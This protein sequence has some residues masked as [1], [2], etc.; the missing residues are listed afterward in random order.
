MAHSLEQSHSP[1]VQQMGSLSGIME[2]A[3]LATCTLLIG[4]TIS[5][6]QFLGIWA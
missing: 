6:E 3:K 2:G 5:S 1:K 4:P